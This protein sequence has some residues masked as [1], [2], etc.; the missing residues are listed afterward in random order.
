MCIN[1]WFTL[2]FD[3]RNY[4][5]KFECD[6]SWFFHG[7]KI[8]F[9]KNDSNIYT[10]YVEFFINVHSCKT[11]LCTEILP[12]SYVL[13][14]VNLTKTSLQFYQAL[15]NT[16]YEFWFYLIHHTRVLNNNIFASSLNH[17]QRSS[18]L[19]FRPHYHYLCTIISR[20]TVSSDMSI[21]HTSLSCTQ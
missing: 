16:F 3:I 11:L 12:S 18:L 6:G 20:N 17:Y 15:Y 10:Y 13:Y 14:S 21:C 5:K 2:S 4:N 1:Q 7:N 8:T 9:L 19:T